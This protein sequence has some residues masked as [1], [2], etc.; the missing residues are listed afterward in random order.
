MLTPVVSYRSNVKVKRAARFALS[1]V[2]FGRN[3]LRKLME[4]DKLQGGRMWDSN[5]DK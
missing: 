5:A 4:S 3:L 1:A 2:A